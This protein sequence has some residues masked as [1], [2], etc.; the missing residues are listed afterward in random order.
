MGKELSDLCRNYLYSNSQR[1][2]RHITTEYLVQ[3]L[4]YPDEGSNFENQLGFS[5]YAFR[6]PFINKLLAKGGLRYLRGRGYDALMLDLKGGII[7]HTAFQV[8]DDNSLHIFSVEIE[9]AY[10]GSS[11]GMYMAE[12]VVTEARKKGIKRIRI[13]AGNHES[14]NKIHKKLGQKEGIVAHEGNWL[15]I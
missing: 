5:K 8:H 7:G 2:Q 1:T 6:V 9:G 15:D 4:G 3:K 10:Q 11:L 14:T 13:G 12:A